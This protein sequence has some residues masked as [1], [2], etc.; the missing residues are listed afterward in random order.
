MRI[1]VGLAF[2]GPIVE[3]MAEESNLAA[4]WAK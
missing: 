2:G 4:A 3:L 1:V